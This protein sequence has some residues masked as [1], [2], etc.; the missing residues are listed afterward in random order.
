[1]SPVAQPPMLDTSRFRPGM[2]ITVACSGGADSVA[3]LRALL[4]KRG[5]LGLVLSIAH[6]N[7]GIRGAEADADQAFVEALAVRF[8]LPIRNRRVDTP[9][10]AEAKHQGLE[11]AARRLRYAWFRELLAG[12]DADAVVTAHT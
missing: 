9:A 10:S 11:E 6:M 1:M 7:H 12:G 8:D 5:A 2:R 4:E 3:L